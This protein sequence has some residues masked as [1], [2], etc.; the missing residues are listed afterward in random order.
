MLQPF[1]QV[2]SSLSRRH[3]GTGLGLPLVVAMMQQ[4]GG[5]LELDSGQGS[6]T[7][8]RLRFPPERVVPR[9]PPAE[10]ARQ[11]DTSAGTRVRAGRTL[12]RTTCAG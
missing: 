2:D 7:T 5:T 10:G 6:G 9:E 12:F 8:A 11:P 3:E 1:V 4:H